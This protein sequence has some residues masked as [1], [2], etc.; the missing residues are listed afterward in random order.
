M[1][2]IAAVVVHTPI[3]VWVLF[4]YL[5]SRGLGALRER[6]IRPGRAL[7]VPIVFLVWGL[8]GLIESRGLGFDL[9]LFAVGLA[10][11]F[12]GGRAI[13]ALTPPPRLALDAGAMTLPG[14]PIPLALIL[15]S[16]AIK[17]VAAVA[18]ALNAGSPAHAEIAS[19]SALVGG[20]F[21]GLF[22]GRSLTQFRRA[23]AAAGLAANWTD[24]A[25][26]AFVRPLASAGGA[27]S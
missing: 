4:A 9:A 16:F 5:L 27:A 2:F 14:S 11:G 8:A 20:F 24:A 12:V 26:L 1:S 18:L 17:Y 22:W 25:R 23:L 21:A 10:A 19:A 3:W 15:V 7:I 6:E 13:A